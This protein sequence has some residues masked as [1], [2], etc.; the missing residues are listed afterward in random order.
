[1]R[2]LVV[3]LR[4]INLARRRRIKMADL[5]ALLEEAGYADVRTLL[6]SGNVV[7][8]TDREPK[9][10]ARDIE[11]AIEART[12]FDVDVVLRTVPE[13]EALVEADP[14]GDLRTDGSRHFVVFCAEPPSAEAV[15]ELEARDFGRERWELR[16]RELVLWCPDGVQDSPLMKAATGARAA[17]TATARNWNTV[18]KLLALARGD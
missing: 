15:A 10:A 4:G 6:Q 14:L 11:R 9:A 2:T 3:L 5:R 12:G 1:M 18:T 7:L 17:R 8:S 13:L 16:E